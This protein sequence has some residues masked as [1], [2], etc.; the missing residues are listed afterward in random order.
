[1]PTARVEGERGR[2]CN[3]LRLFAKVVRDGQFLEA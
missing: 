1:L 3:Q 2:T